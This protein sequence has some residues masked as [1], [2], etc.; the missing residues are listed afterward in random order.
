M[1]VIGSISR[2]LVDPLL[3]Q[4]RRFEVATFSAAIGGLV[5]VIGGVALFELVGSAVHSLVGGAS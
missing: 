1:P 3:A 2:A 5:L 4:K